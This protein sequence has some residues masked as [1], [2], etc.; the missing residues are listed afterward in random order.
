MRVYLPILFIIVLTV[1][2]YSQNSEIAR[3]DYLQKSK[4]QRTAGWLLLGGGTALML[5]GI[6]SGSG[7]SEGDMGYGSNFDS[8]MALFGVGLAADII[9]IPM[10][11]SASKNKK[12]ADTLFS[13]S[14]M[15]VVVY[16]NTT[17]RFITSISI[18]IRF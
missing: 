4:N 9:S 10:F 1:K 2:L 6:S 13:F 18:S 12:R 7:G 11:V 5:A 14:P 8:G 16:N 3:S 15:P 17:T